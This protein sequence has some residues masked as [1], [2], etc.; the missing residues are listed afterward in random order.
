MAIWQYA[1]LALGLAWLLQCVGVWFQMRQ[2]AGVFKGVTDKF[3]DG[4]VGA[5][6][7]RGG[8]RP[9]AIALVVV[10]REGLVR[11]LL[12]MSGRS[13][14]AR[15]RRVETVEGRPLTALTQGQDFKITRSESRA[16]DQ[17]IGQIDRVCARAKDNEIAHAEPAQ[18]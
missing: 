8:F 11:R 13:V 16:I 17:A 7:V 15:F 12:L 14:F 10:D 18:G 3:N 9:G 1:L 4:F 6:H 2:Y 5:G